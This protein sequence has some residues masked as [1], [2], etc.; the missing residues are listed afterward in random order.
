GT[1]GLSMG[2]G[3]VRSLSAVFSPIGKLL[4]CFAMFA[5]RLG[6]LT[7]AVAVISKKEEMFRYPEGNVVIG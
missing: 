7:L 6:P 2:D 3:G 4:I 1:V 5:G